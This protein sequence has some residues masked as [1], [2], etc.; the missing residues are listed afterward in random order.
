MRSGSES[1]Q[2]SALDTHILWII[3][4]RERD[5]RNRKQ[6]IASHSD[7]TINEGPLIPP[8]RVWSLSAVRL[9]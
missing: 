2:N 9:W 3:D 5:Q 8:A 6:S 7:D 1:I 4:G